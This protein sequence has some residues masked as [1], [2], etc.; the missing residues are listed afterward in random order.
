MSLSSV[1]S[2]TAIP[3]GVVGLA[4]PAGE[5]RRLLTASQRTRSRTFGCLPDGWRG[6][7]VFDVL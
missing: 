2:F 4:L 7:A 6:A 5:W 3:Q 1:D